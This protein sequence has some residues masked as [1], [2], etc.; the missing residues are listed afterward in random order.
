MIK[1]IYLTFLDVS[2]VWLCYYVLLL[3][4]LCLLLLRVVAG[5]WLPWRLSLLYPWF[6][7]NSSSFFNYSLNIGKPD[8]LPMTSFKSRC[9]WEWVAVWTTALS[10]CACRLTLYWETWCLRYLVLS[11]LFVGY[12]TFAASWISRWHCMPFFRLPT[13]PVK[14]HLCVYKRP[15]Q[16]G[17][18]LW[19]FASLYLALANSPFSLTPTFSLKP[20][21]F[22]SSYSYFSL[23]V[24]LCFIFN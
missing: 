18:Q 17:F 19:T 15:L 23:F 6:P 13:Y 16:D 1:K 10:Q 21:L 12:S 5:L 14:V 11:L 2:N 24:L 9:F 7:N 22:S 8:L 3:L 20:F 4:L